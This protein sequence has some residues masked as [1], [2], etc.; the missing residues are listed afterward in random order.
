MGV[1][2]TNT[3]PTTMLTV[4]SSGLK[5]SNTTTNY[6]A[7]GLNYYEQT[8]IT[9]AF[10]GAATVSVTANVI[11]TGKSVI[12]HVPQSYVTTT[13]GS[14]FTTTAI[15]ARFRPTVRIVQVLRAR[16]NTS[17]YTGFCAIDTTGVITIYGDIGGGNFPTGTANSGWDGFSISFVSA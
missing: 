15:D 4:D 2:D 8:T 12:I 13:A 6:V 10:T 14:V 16:S 11:R 5:F 1:G 9:L 7:S 3:Q 17:Y